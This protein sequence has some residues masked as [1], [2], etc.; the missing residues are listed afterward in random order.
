MTDF[1]LAKPFEQAQ[2]PRAI[3]NEIK[4]DG[5]RIM[6]SVETGK[7]R[8]AN[9][10]G[11]DKAHT[12]PEVVARLR[13]LNQD[14]V[15]DGEVIAGESEGGD[16]NALA[17]RSHRQNPREA[18]IKR[19]PVKF[20]AF[21]LLRL[22][23]NDLTTRPYAY[24][25]RLLEMV[26][27]MSYTRMDPTTGIGSD[28]LPTT[29]AFEVARALPSNV[30]EAMHYVRAHGLEG[31]IIKDAASHYR[32]GRTNA[33]IKL[34]NFKEMEATV[35]AVEITDKQAAVLLCRLPNGHLQRVVCPTR[36]AQQGDRVEL[37]YLTQGETG[38]LRFPSYK[39][40]LPR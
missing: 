22:T 18:D 2:M 10:R 35:E 17:H 40:R 26:A 6:A 29:T 5:E 39:G 12:Y 8:L 23:R 11:I 38:A 25:R 24:R 9:R 7:I 4:Y 32:P 34:K 37:Q 30:D 14:I 1:A 3:A 33:F 13:T 16:F 27:G 20:V 15:L 28:D 21:D 31:I 19:Y 36:E